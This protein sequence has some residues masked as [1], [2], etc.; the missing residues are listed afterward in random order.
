[1]SGI[2]KAAM[3][4]TT[5]DEADRY[6]GL[7]VEATLAHFPAMSRAKAE[8]IARYN[9]GYFAGYYD[10][11]VRARV[12]RLFK[13]VHPYFGAIAE[14]GPLTA[15]DIFDLGLKHGAQMRARDE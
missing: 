8:H 3:Q 6:L 14:T 11:E 10:A 1:M 4:A 2:L 7:L 12:E 13:C 15:Q 5:Q 9:L